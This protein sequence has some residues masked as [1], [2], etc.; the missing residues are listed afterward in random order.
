MR[1]STMRNSPMHDSEW[2]AREYDAMG[3]DYKTHNE[4]SSWN[5][6]Y[7]RPATISLIGN[8]DGLRVLEAGCGPG[9]LTEWLT[10]HGA[11]VT[12]FDVSPEMVRL[13][14]A[15]TTGDA[16]V[17]VADLAQPLTF[18]PDASQDLIVASLV[19]HYIADW[20][21][22]L[23]E[24]HRVLTDDGAVVFSIDH[25]ASAWQYFTPDNYFAVSQ[26][27][28]TW[29]LS[30]QN[31][32]VTY[33]K[34]PLTTTTQAISDAGFLIDRLTEPQPLPE[35]AQRTPEDHNWLTTRPAFL[36]FRLVKRL[37]SNTRSA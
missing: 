2:T 19:L 26:V 36:F 8:P 11:T 17:F 29:P 35:A 10:T 13:A 3:A 27:T 34:R 16:N 14:R 32:E 5:A 15:R 33:W 30:G 18:V 25:P 21:P 20:A 24:F 4:E 6:L 23:T 31:Y 9:A 1:S 28:S 37:A 12:A 22:V 7:E